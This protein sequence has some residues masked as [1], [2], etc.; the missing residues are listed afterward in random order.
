M[1]YPG[2]IDIIKEFKSSQRRELIPMLVKIQ[3]SIGYIPHNVLSEISLYLKIPV[4]KIY[5]VASFFDDIRFEE[6]G[7]YHIK[8]CR[9]TDCYV[10]ESKSILSEIIKQIGI[11]P[12]ETSNDGIVSLEI[13]GC[14]GGCGSSPVVK[15]ND[16]YHSNVKVEDVT[17][18]LSSYLSKHSLYD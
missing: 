8:V 7:K 2:V 10:N 5:A 3:E 13:T 9:G 12:G 14:L 4:S 16:N 11:N 6:K 1:E 15:V 17:K 18:I